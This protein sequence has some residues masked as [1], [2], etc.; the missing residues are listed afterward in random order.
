MWIKKVVRKEFETGVSI[1][2]SRS[3]QL[4]HHYRAKRAR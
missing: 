3:V 1:D 2:P 4:Y